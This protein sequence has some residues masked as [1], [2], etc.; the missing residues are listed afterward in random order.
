MEC[1]TA[2]AGW[3]EES[4]LLEP[5]VE[6]L[7]LP[8][9]AAIAP[10]LETS[11]FPTKVVKKERFDYLQNVLFSR[12]MRSESAALILVHYRLKE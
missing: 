8:Q 10:G 12:I 11:E 1:T 6:D 7:K 2:S 9:A 4:Q 3:I 5:I